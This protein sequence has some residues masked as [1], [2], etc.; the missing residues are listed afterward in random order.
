[1]VVVVCLSYVLHKAQ[2][3]DLF[4]HH[5]KDTSRKGLTASI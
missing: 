5:P 1:M 2:V 3:R 4:S